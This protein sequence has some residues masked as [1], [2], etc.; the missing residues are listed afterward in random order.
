MTE[1]HI[2]QSLTKEEAF[3]LPGKAH[4]EIKLPGMPPETQSVELW[5]QYLGF[6]NWDWCTLVSL[7]SQDEPIRCS[8]CGTTYKPGER[9]A[10]CKP[11]PAPV[12]EIEKEAALALLALYRSDVEASCKIISN[13][14]Q[15][16]L[17]IAEECRKYLRAYDY[18]KSKG[19]L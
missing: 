14:Q 7:P 11:E 9:H 17:G 12:A 13:C 1:L 10:C 8:D 18:A 4:I 3:S 5:K 2:G 6:G 19:A 16:S 15:E